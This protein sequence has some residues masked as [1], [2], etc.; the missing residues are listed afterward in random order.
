MSMGSVVDNYAIHVYLTSMQY[1]VDTYA[2]HIMYVVD[3]HICNA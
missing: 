2:I 1:I 3:R